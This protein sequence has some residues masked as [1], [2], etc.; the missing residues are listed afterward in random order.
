MVFCNW[1]PPGFPGSQGLDLFTDLPVL[2]RTLTLIKHV[3]LRKQNT[4]LLTEIKS[5]A[6]KEAKL[7]RRRIH[8]KIGYEASQQ[9]SG[10]IEK[11]LQ[12][13][14]KFNVIAAY[15]PINTELDLRPTIRKLRLLG[16]KICL[17]LI[18]SSNSPLQFKI[19][20]EDTK[21][22][23]G[24]FDV[25]V[26]TSEESVEPD[27]ILCPMLS[28]DLEGFR[29]GYGGGFYDRTIEHLSERKLIFTMG[30]GYSQQLSLKLIPKGKYDKSL[31]AAVTERG[32]TLFKK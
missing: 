10:Y 9:I 7:H 32:I 15:L 20:E 21:L 14:T 27:L 5:A 25:M 16:K 28:F 30:C 17:P 1:C 3:K 12:E 6:R 19:W 13:R 23:I 26:P 8:D 11:F 18:I 4:L 29:L 31:D 22:A 2:S 24:K